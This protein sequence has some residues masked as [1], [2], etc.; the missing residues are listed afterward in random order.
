MKAV[1]Q[2]RID[3][4]LTMRINTLSLGSLM[5]FMPLGP[6]SGYY[7]KIIILGWNT[8]LNSRR[9]ARSSPGVMRP[10]NLLI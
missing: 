2:S 3:V 4:H 6:F 8:Y 7:F 5:M 9:P 10:G 1:L